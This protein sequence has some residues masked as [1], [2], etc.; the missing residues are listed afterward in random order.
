MT[1]QYRWSSITPDDVE[2]WSQLSNHLGEVDGTEEFYSAQDLAEELDSAGLQP[3]RDTWAVW[4]DQDMVGYGQLWITDN[5]DPE[6]YIK[7]SLVGG[8][9]VDHR[10]RGL[11]RRLMDL[12]E[13]RV[14]QAV[15]ERHPD[16]PFFFGV[17]GGLEGSSARR[18]LMARDYQVARYF[19]LLGR[20]LTAHD[21]VP[22]I[23]DRPLTADDV[24]FRQPRHGDESAVLAAH[25]AAFRDHW[26]YSPIS[27]QRWHEHWSASNNRPEVCTLAV[28]DAGQVL[29]YALCGQ[30]VDREIYVHLVGTVPQARGTGLG[31]TVLAHTIEAAAQS[32]DFDVIELDVDTESPTGATRLYERLGFTVKH[33]T[34]A[35][36][37][38]HA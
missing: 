33:T 24:V 7:T 32:G 36:R 12:M 19:S 8:V 13:T 5:T 26:G 16:T 28:D 25:Q 20:P 6:G 9:H 23:L 37:K 35:M 29:A 34:A 17:S 18:M 31:S 15:A 21:T 10:G 30:W 14:V 2:Q 11:G 3:E 22:E 38:Y 4:Q 27:E 1:E